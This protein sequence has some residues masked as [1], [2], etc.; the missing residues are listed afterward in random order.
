VGAR[1]RSLRSRRAR[2]VPLSVPR[3]APTGA[4]CGR[5]CATAAVPT[6]SGPALTRTR[7]PSFRKAPMSST[8]RMRRVTAPG[9]SRRTL[10]QGRQ[11]ELATVACCRTTPGCRPTRAPA[12]ATARVVPTGTSPAQT[13]PPTGRSSNSTNP[14]TPDVPSSAHAAAPIS[15]LPMP[16]KTVPDN[17]PV[18]TSEPTVRPTSPTAWPKSCS[19]DRRSIAARIPSPV[20]S[21]LRT[22]TPKGLRLRAVVVLIMIGPRLGARSDRSSITAEG[23]SPLRGQQPAGVPARGSRAVPAGGKRAPASD[24]TSA[25]SAGTRPPGVL[26]AAHGSSR[27]WADRRTPRVG[28]PYRLAPM[29]WCGRPEARMTGGRDAVSRSGGHGGRVG[30][31][32]ARPREDPP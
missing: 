7:Q 27:R 2:P 9:P 23:S 31:P 19:T 30:T 21:R 25:V 32:P 10:A 22:R 20:T 29:P 24:G 13:G 28:S 16:S 3:S 5:R 15:A 14:S 18:A 6:T 1:P 12:R 17:D 26:S 8:A 11:A 4:A